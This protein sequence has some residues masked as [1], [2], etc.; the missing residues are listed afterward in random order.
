M[1]T[2]VKKLLS[3]LL[4]L[5]LVFLLVCP[6]FADAE[7]TFKNVILMIGDGMGENHLLLAREHGVDLFMDENCD[8]HGFSRTR[9]YSDLVTDSAAGGT[10][11]ACGIR[12]INYAVGVY[13]FDRTSKLAV[14]RSLTEVARDRGMRTGI[15]T[16]DKTS[17]A[18][19]A[20]FTAHTASRENNEDIT[21][22]Q[23]ASGFD[24]LWGNKETSADP[25]AIAAAG[26]TLVTTRAGMEA[27]TPGSRSFGQFSG[28]T[29]RTTLAPDGATPMLPAMTAKALELL[30]ANNNKGF[31]LMVEGAHI[32]KMSHKVEDGVHYPSK[33]TRTVDAVKSFDL[34]V[35]AAADFAKKDGHTL[36]LVT[37]D[38]ETGNL[39]PENGVL[40]FHSG[41]HT[42][43]DVPVLVF[44]SKTVVKNGETLENYRIPIRLAKALG[45]EE[46]AFPSADPGRVLRLLLQ[47][48]DLLGQMQKMTQY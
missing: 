37:A 10:A 45:W 25:A 8:A 44:G 6:A 9:S 7:K 46:A 26:W 35:K 1:K 33:V 18:T 13:P 39:Y 27:L 48:K 36:V 21:A 15:V 22:Q 23:I 40:T 42:S 28:D 3:T 38:H 47:I 31:F 12:T 20:D 11:L 24:L 41:E 5:S 43:A 34:A 2:R 19:P 17:G 14:P 16:T 32:D 29:W 4:A 30:S